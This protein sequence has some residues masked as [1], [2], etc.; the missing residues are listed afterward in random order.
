M[1]VSGRIE[2]VG[3]TRFLHFFL[4][5]SSTSTISLCLCCHAHAHPLSPP[6]SAAVLHSASTP[7]VAALFSLINSQ[8]L[9]A[10]KPALG[11]VL[12]FLYSAWE[13]DVGAYQDITSGNNKYGPCQGFDAISGWDAVSVFFS[14][15]FF[16]CPSPLEKV[17]MLCLV[18]SARELAFPTGPSCRNWP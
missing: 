3:G 17:F 18:P 10:K 1:E 15:S 16:L 11:F 4:F 5:L 9:T 2:N 12:P 13:Q 6:L 7:T 14:L 8:R